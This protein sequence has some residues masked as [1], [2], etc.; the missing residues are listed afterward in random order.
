MKNWI[1]QV[2]LG[3]DCFLNAVFGGYHRETYSSRCHRCAY[4]N[5]WRWIE[6]IVDALF[7]PLQGWG[8]CKNAYLKGLS[9]VGLPPDYLDLAYAMNGEIS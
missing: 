6:K 5:P 8:H 3:F 1:Y 4:R 7:W 9:G 2:V